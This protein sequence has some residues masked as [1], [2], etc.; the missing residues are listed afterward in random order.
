MHLI[1][2]DK[3]VLSSN[4]A[5]RRRLNI[6]NWLQ[7]KS[8][9]DGWNEILL[10]TDAFRRMHKLKILHINYSEMRGDYAKFP[11]K[12]VWFRWD[13]CPLQYIPS[14]F[15]LERSVAVE[16]RHSDL[17]AGWEGNKVIYSP[18]LHFYKLDFRS[19]THS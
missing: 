10:K 17:K 3:K 18:S 16:I 8:A 11:K 15:P 19:R 7:S 2:E 6:F 12:I 1:K 14:D 13:G 4:I 5:I 9:S